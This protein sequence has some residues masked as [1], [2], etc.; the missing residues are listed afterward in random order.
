MDGNRRWAR[1]EVVDALRS[2]LRERAGTGATADQL[3]RTL[4]VDDIAAHLDTAGQP[5][6]DLVPTWSSAARPGPG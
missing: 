4:T 3:A 2:L 5:D 1:T 6:P